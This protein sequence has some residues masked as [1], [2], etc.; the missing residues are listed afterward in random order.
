MQPPSFQPITVPKLKTFNPDHIKQIYAAQQEELNAINQGLTKRSWTT[1]FTFWNILL[2]TITTLG[3]TYLYY[4]IRSLKP[5]QT[6]QPLSITY[7]PS[8]I[9]DH[10]LVYTNTCY[11]I[12]TTST[13]IAT[14]TTALNTIHS[15]ERSNCLNPHAN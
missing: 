1:Y 4:Q 8:A 3:I 15:P 11:S 13:N 10:E 6:T 5:I 2:V 7:L 12:P 9:P 14:E